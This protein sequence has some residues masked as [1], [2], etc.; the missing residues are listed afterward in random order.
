M[1]VDIATNFGTDDNLAIATIGDR[2]VGTVCLPYKS[3]SCS[4]DV[5]HAQTLVP[6]L[7]TTLARMLSGALEFALSTRDTRARYMV[8]F[9]E[10][11]VGVA[12]CFW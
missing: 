1:S 8:M 3:C 12:G 11:A 7:H 4:L 6:V 2:V 10:L 5:I 9:V